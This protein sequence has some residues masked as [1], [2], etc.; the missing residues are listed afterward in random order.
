MEKSS[1][2]DWFPT[3]AGRQY[4]A[5]TYSPL[6][7]DSERVEAVLAIT[8]DLT[9]HARA[10]EALQRAQAE[11]AHVTRV[12]T[13]GEL[14]ASI[15]HEVNQPLAAI[16][17]DANASLNWLAAADP[18][19]AKI[20]DALAAV[21]KGGHRA[22]HVILR[23]RQLVTK[24]EPQRARVDVDDAIRDVL[25]LVRSEV[26]SHDVSFRL[27][28]APTL[29]PVL[30]DRVQL[31]QVLIN[32]VMNGID[33]MGTVDDR[34][35]TLVIRSRPHEGDQVLVAVEDAGIG[36][37]PEKVDQLFSAFFTSKPGGTFHFTLP[38][39]R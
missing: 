5:A 26:R 13:L 7:P 25:P 22:A 6:R 3:P 16:V 28:L 39:M 34:P 30:S 24:S 2:V 27:D 15:A 11:L 31:Q 20:R 38:G 36:I 4:L 33:A 8:R 9:D 18:D 17:A 29:Q 35:R 10:S 37:D 21:V 23:I 1:F 19:L 14:A 12:A 32:P